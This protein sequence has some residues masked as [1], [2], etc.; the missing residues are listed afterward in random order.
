MKWE[1]RFLFTYA[2]S[3]L[4]GTIANGSLNYIPFDLQST[5]LPHW[6]NFNS[7][8]RCLFFARISAPS[9]Q[10][11]EWKYLTRDSCGS[12]FNRSRK[13]SASLI[14]TRAPLSTYSTWERIPLF[15]WRATR[16]SFLSFYSRYPIVNSLA[17]FFRTPIII[18]DLLT[19]TAAKFHLHFR[20]HGKIPN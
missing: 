13:K 2:S 11:K 3:F 16:K 12:S 18:I 1:Q 6:G 7:L 20:S 8:T 17:A 5:S 19:L 15:P 4:C 10:R 9:G 14:N